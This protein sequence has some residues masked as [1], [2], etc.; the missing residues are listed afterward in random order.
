MSSGIDEELYFSIN[1]AANVGLFFIVV[2]PT[3]TLCLLCVLAL[4]FAE[5][6]NWP[7][8]V[9]LINV[10]AADITYWVALSILF[11][12]FPARARKLTDEDFS[13]RVVFSLFIV[14]AIQKFSSVA[15]YAIMVYI[16][17]R[18]GSKKTKWYVIGPYI[19]I[20][21]ILSIGNGL[22]P[23]FDQFG[24][25]NNNGFCKNT[26][27]PLFTATVSTMIVAVITLFLVIVSFG[28]L[29]LFYVK[30]D[31]LLQDNVEI[32]KEIAKNL[33]YLTVT[34]VLSLLYNL[35]PASFPFIK[36]AAT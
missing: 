16:F 31:A 28:A 4:L 10:L 26:S 21:W 1:T 15:L 34:T 35:I 7:M 30:R 19:V 13:C 3:L 2:L 24:I 5:G 20:S 25:I 17:I 8:R 12:G 33:L 27:T 29:T 6:I 32:K 14:S 22:P 18:F 23:Y 11:P 9:V 36:A